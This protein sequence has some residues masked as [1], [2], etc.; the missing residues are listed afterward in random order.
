MF[1]QRL[2]QLDDV[3]LFGDCWKKEISDVCKSIHI[4]PHGVCESIYKIDMDVAR[5]ALGI[6]HEGKIIL[7]MN[8]NQPRKR[9]DIFAIALATYYMK[10]P[11]ST[12]RCMIATS[13]NG[14]WDLPSI[15][16]WEFKRK[17]LSYTDYIWLFDTQNLVEDDKI[18]LLYNAC[19][20]GINV[21]D[22]E[23][24]GLCNVEHGSLGMPQIVTDLPI[25]NEIFDDSAL[26]ANIC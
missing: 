3:Y 16:E 23:G 5:D 4:V 18:N 15:L 11:S 20:I 14:A 17:S 7:N 9:Y 24:F 26:Y 13:I 25:F 19:D 8:R 10:N 22:G 2:Q 1:K 12:I 21:C 6:K